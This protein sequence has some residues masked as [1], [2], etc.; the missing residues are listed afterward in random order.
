MIKIPIIQQNKDYNCGEAVVQA[1]LLY[2]GSNIK[3]FR[4]ASE[5]DG[6]NPRV[7]EHQLRLQGFN[8]VSGNFGWELLK[9]YIKKKLAVIVCSDGHWKIVCGIENRSVIFMDP[10]YDVYQKIS[11]IKF[12]DSWLD[13]DSMAVKYRSWGIVANPSY[14]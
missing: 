8:V 12:K 6:T 1:L 7:I 4:F 9:Y 13:Y 3:N 14:G 5:V 11:I 10:L 2:Y